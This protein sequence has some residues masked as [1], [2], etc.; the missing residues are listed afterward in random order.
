VRLV[1]QGR[2]EEAFDD[3]FWEAAGP[4]ARVEALWGM[5]LDHYAFRGD[6]AAYEPGLQRSILR[7]RRE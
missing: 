7:L 1:R 3:A 6:H 2:E 5:L 4:K